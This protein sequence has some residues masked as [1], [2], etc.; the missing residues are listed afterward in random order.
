MTSRT[1]LFPFSYSHIKPRI[2]HLILI[3]CH[4][5]NSTLTP[6]FLPHSNTSHSIYT[7]V[8]VPAFHC[9]VTVFSTPFTSFLCKCFSHIIVT[10]Y[11]ILPHF[12][13][14]SLYHLC[15]PPSHNTASGSISNFIKLYHRS[16]LA[17]HLIADS[18]R[19]YLHNEHFDLLDFTCV[20]FGTTPDLS[21]SSS[22]ISRNSSPPQLYT[23]PPFFL[24]HCH[25]DYQCHTLVPYI[26]SKRQS[27]RSPS[28]YTIAITT[29][30]IH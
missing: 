9:H 24:S 22:H 19:T 23:F 29:T 11:I 12:S 28:S 26:L 1:L 4:C 16:F 5:I 17:S 10:L 3:P 6:H 15:F 27:F 25:C 20:A 2:S 8:P 14:Q 21:S 7:S 13:P 18:S 30:T